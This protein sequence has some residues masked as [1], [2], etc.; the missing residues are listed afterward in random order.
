MSR[1]APIGRLEESTE[2]KVKLYA[3]RIKDSFQDSMRME[4]V[5]KGRILAAPSVQR[6]REKHNLLLF[7][8]LRKEQQLHEL[9]AAL[10]ALSAANLHTS[11]DRDLTQS[12]RSAELS[13]HSGPFL[14]LNFLKQESF[15]LEQK[16]EKEKISQDQ[17]V[18]VIKKTKEKIV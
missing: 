6:L 2:G 4:S 5:H 3:E 10:Q 12:A 11:S 9:Q 16:T 7:S 14:R 1:L 13:D 18:Y 17:L 8:N 15:D